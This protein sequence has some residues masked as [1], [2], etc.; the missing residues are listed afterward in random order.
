M[1]PS[2]WHSPN[3]RSDLMRAELSIPP[4][5]KY[6]VTTNKNKTRGDKKCPKHRQF[7]GQ[8]R[9][10]KFPAP[11]PK[12]KARKWNP[13]P[14][15]LDEIRLECRCRFLLCFKYAAHRSCCMPFMIE[16]RVQIFI[17]SFIFIYIYI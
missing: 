9:E 2:T 8:N 7:Q 15:I 13:I 16:L 3:L 17:L 5:H 4:I 10:N 14:I 11:T 6:Y 1:Q 12:N